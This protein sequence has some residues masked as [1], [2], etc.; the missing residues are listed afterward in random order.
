M[1]ISDVASLWSDSIGIST[2]R[3]LAY[4][5]FLGFAFL[6]FFFLFPFYLTKFKIHFSDSGFDDTFQFSRIPRQTCFFRHLV[7]GFVPIPE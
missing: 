1:L 6:L 7:P 4:S 5:G 3:I 2:R